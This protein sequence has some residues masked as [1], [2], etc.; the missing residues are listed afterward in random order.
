V[1]V[2]I[3]INSGVKEMNK[4][5]RKAVVSLIKTILY[6]MTGRLRLDRTQIGERTK[7]DDGQ[8]Y[9]V[10]RKIILNPQLK[11][12]NSPPAILKIRFDF[13]HGSPGQNKLLSIIPI[14]FITGFPGFKSKTWSINTKSGGFQ[15]VYEWETPLDAEAYKKSFAV[16]LMTKRAVPGSVSFTILTHSE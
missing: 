10:F 8:E 6:T 16:K 3:P 4:F 7:I 9:I 11:D 13:A 15:G 1:K 2:S 5:K 12:S 14:P